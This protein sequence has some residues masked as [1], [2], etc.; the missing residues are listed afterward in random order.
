MS[1]VVV[2][3]SKPW[4][5]GSEYDNVGANGGDKIMEEAR[6]LTDNSSC[7]ICTQHSEIVEHLVAGCTKLENSKYLTRHNQ[8]LMIFTMFV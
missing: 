2:S 3:D 8:A 7:R 6:L 4:E 5:N 1:R